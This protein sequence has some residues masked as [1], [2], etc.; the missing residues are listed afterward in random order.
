MTSPTRTLIPLAWADLTRGDE[1]AVRAALARDAWFDADLLVQWE[2]AWS[3]LWDRPAVAFADPVELVAALKL[4]LNWP[5]GACIAAD[6]LLEPVWREACAAAWLHLVWHDLDPQTGLIR[7]QGSTIVP[8]GSG[9]LAAGFWRHA[10][11][12][13]IRPSVA[14]VPPPLLM[15]EISGVIVPLPGCG[16]GG[17]QL[18]H[19]DG[20]GILPAGT[21]C[22]LLSRNTA[23]VDDLRRLRRHPPGNAACALGLSLLSRLDETLAR[24]RQLA[25]RYLAM[26]PR[27]RFR[28]PDTT[29]PASRG[30]TNFFLLLDNP[31]ERNALRDY[32]ARAHI[33]AASPIWYQPDPSAGQLPGVRHFLAHSLAIPFYPALDLT[34]QKRVINRVH[35]WT[36]IK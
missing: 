36:V 12:Q 28:P 31:P 7:E 8:P 14:W 27:G 9:A 33:G 1:G 6:A 23:L 24:R 15:E 21:G 19:F 4:R 32:L 35:R 29:D 34:A 16:W 10:F 3:V 17:I 18:L 20:N 2:R 5:S 13:P 22:L 26:R 25:A 30:W 11:G